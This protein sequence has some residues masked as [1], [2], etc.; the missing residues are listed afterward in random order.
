A[1]GSLAERDELVRKPLFLEGANV[2]LLHGDAAMP[3]NCTKP[4][5]NLVVVAPVEILLAELAALVAH[6][7]LGRASSTPGRLIKHNAD[8][9]GCRSPLEGCKAEGAARPVVDD[10]GNPPAERPELGEG[11]GEPARPEA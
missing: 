11:E 10:D 9:L 3:A 4:S 1:E 5:A 2:P 6:R 7:V 8:L